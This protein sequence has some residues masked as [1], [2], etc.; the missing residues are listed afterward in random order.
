MIKVTGAGPGHRGDLLGQHLGDSRASCFRR[1]G[2]P[3]A[4]W[5]SESEC[6]Q[7]RAAV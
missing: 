1:G 6:E 3:G 2:R 4:Q 5:G 7:D